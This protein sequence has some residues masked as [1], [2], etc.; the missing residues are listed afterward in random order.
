MEEIDKFKAFRDERF[1]YHVVKIG[2][3][4]RAQIGEYLASQTILFHCIPGFSRKEGGVKCQA[5]KIFTISCTKLLT[6]SKIVYNN[7][8]HWSRSNYR[9]R[10]GKRGGSLRWYLS[11]M[12]ACPMR[13]VQN[14]SD[15]CDQRIHKVVFPLD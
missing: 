4:I 12:L 14:I 9:L 11:F 1:L 5:I 10:R 3:W 13:F 2:S 7:S 8:L 6:N 15:H